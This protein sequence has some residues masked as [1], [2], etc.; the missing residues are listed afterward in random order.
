[1]DEPMPWYARFILFLLKAAVLFLGFA[2]VWLIHDAN[3]VCPFSINGGGC[4]PHA[5]NGW[6]SVV[7]IAPI[8]VPAVLGSMFIVGRWAW[9]L[10]RL[11]RGQP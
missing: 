9:R 7:V 5:V 8:G 1:M 11:K 2:Y 10:L 4:D 3:D 6:M